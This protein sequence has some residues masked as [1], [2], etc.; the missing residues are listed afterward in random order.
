MYEK[1]LAK[2]K[3]ATIAMGRHEKGR[4]KEVQ[5]YIT[6]VFHIQSCILADA[7]NIPKILFTVIGLDLFS[8]N[9]ECLNLTGC[10]DG[11][12]LCAIVRLSSIVR[13]PHTNL[14]QFI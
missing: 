4:L 2:S 14:T 7:F 10:L 6:Y 13:A 1:L 9:R 3:Q 8:R 11:Q 12:T 5:Q